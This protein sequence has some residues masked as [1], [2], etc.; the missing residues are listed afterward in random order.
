MGKGEVNKRKDTILLVINTVVT[1]LLYTL[2]GVGA[3]SCSKDVGGIGRFVLPIIMYINILVAMLVQI[4][5]HEGGHLIA[6]LLSGYEFVSFRIFSW[7]WVKGRDKKLHIK[8]MKIKGTA[9]QCLMCPPKVPIESSPYM[10]YHLG[11]GLMNLVVGGVCTILY[12]FVLPQKCLTFLL[13]EEFGIVGI[14][15]GLT[16]LI[17]CKLGGIQNDGYNLL[18]LSKN[19]ETRKCMNMVLSINAYLTLADSYAELPKEL[20]DEMKAVDF[21]KMDITNGSVL[22][23]YSYQAALYFVE[24]NYEEAYRVQKHILETE[25]TLEIFRNEARCECLFYELTHGQD[26]E[27]IEKLYD[28]K[29]QKYIKATAIY[30]SKLRLM[31]A[32]YYLY[33]KDDQKVQEI[34]AK[35]E[36]SVDTYMIKVDAVAELATVKKLMQASDASENNN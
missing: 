4:I 29:L 19:L 13:F 22:N 31:F 16:N 8:K 3:F 15:L 7:V 11:G 36:R 12:H 10:L 20:I 14:A 9:G 2:I 25:G 24:G 17:P 32:Y 1:I 28:K 23:A 6:G 26:K 35:L 33:E 34:Y 18:D 27:T 30:P 21:T 5:L